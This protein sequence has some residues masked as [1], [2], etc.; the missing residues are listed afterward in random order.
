MSMGV[1][2]IDSGCISFYLSC[3]KHSTLML[4]LLFVRYLYVILKLKHA[5]LIVI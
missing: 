4:L 5:A 2:F 3:A 1:L